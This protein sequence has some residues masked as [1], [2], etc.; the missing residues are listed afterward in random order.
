M[1]VEREFDRNVEDVQYEISLKE[2]ARKLPLL[3]NAILYSWSVDGNTNTNDKWLVKLPI[4]KY[5]LQSSFNCGLV[6]A[7][8][9][10]EH[11]MDRV[12]EEAA[13]D[14]L[15]MS[16]KRGYSREGEMFSAFDLASITMDYF[17]NP[18]LVPYDADK[19]WRPCIQNGHR[20]HWAMIIGFVLPMSSMHR[21][22]IN[23][24][25]S[26]SSSNNIIN[27]HY[28]NSKD[29]TSSSSLHFMDTNDSISITLGNND[30]DHVDDASS[31]QSKSQSHL[32]LDPRDVLLV[33]H[34][35]KSKV[36][37][38][39]EY[40]LLNESNSSLQEPDPARLA[41]NRWLIPPKL[42]NLQHKW[43]FIQRHSTNN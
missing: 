36:T 29:K 28:F 33:C 21:G 42:T 26:T 40:S 12:Y 18:I 34:H 15:Q 37:G 9:A 35:S 14:M 24:N 32:R 31:L 25:Q 41:E 4:F 20:P 10:I 1:T 6:A 39:W 30:Y 17:G 23:N 8:M 2:M 5:R 27:V 11:L 19:N 3:L 7:R 22:V 43:I 13:M 38:L 16:I